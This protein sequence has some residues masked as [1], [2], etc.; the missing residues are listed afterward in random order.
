VDPKSLLKNLLAQGD[1]EKH[2]FERRMKIN[3]NE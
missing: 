3:G 1:K 2:F